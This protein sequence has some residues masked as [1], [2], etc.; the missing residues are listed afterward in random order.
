MIITTTKEAMTAKIHQDEPQN[1]A[2]QGYVPSI[3]QSRER[4]LLA[5]LVDDDDND[6]HRP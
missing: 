5:D 4:P 1:L 6:R 3:G 2:Q